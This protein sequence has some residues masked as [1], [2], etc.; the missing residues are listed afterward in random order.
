MKSWPSIGTTGCN[1]IN[2]IDATR[3]PIADHNCADRRALVAGTRTQMER[4]GACELE[5]FVTQTSVAAAVEEARHLAG[6]AHPSRSRATAY[7]T[8]PNDAFDVDHPRR[9]LLASS[10]RVVGYDQ[11]PRSHVI[12]QL[13]EWQPLMDFVAEVLN[14]PTVYRYADP[15]GALNIAVMGDGDAL[16]WHF[17]QTDFVLSIPLVAAERG[18]DFEVHPLIR[19]AANERYDAVDAALTDT[20]P[21][22][23]R[24]PMRAGSLLLFQGR[25][26]LHR[27][28]PI[29]GARDR[30]VALL[31]YDT[32][33]GTDSTAELKLAR[34]GRTAPLPLPA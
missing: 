27:V 25:N 11:I 6:G 28:T 1:R 9:R 17:D 4:F 26:S 19:S 23:L 16:A 18:G 14:L 2:H 5:G 10:V 7:L 34:Y 29:G 13:Y 3:Y 22:P 32:K 31:A 8:A 30:I 21:T 15:M 20:G 12:R 33:P 24:L